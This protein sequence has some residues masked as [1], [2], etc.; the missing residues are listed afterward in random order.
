ME[1]RRGPGRKRPAH[2]IGVE[3]G[4]RESGDPLAHLVSLPPEALATHALLL[5]ATGSGKTTLIH[6][7]IAQDVLLGRSFVILDLRGDLVAAAAGLL[8][9]RVPP[10]RVR[11]LDLRQRANPAGFDPLHGAGEPYFRALGV[12]GAVEAAS[13]SWGVQLAETL[14]SALTLLAA[15]GEPLTRI[16]PLLYDRAFLGSCLTGCEDASLAGFWRRYLEL[17][18]AKQGALAAPVMNKVSL[19]LSTGPLRSIL[20]SERPLDLRRQLDT[21]GSALLVSLA[22]DETH[23][24]GRMMGR[25][26]L[27]SLVREVFARVAIPESRRNPVRLYV[28]EFSHFGE[29]E[30]EG[31]LA[32]GRRFGLSLVVAHQTLAQLA[33]RMRAM[34]LG[35]VGAKVAFRLGRD[36]AAIMSRDLTGDPKA[37]DLTGQRTGEAT[38]WTRRG[39]VREIE[40][41]API[42][43][44]AGGATPAAHRLLRA[45]REAADAA[46]RLPRRPLDPPS[47]EREPGAGRTSRSGVRKDAAS[48]EDWLL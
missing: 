26:F 28:D 41:N 18:D 16:E 5:G 10:E 21:P 25:I 22:A 23:G 37:L 17:S 32:E 45:A 43:P 15:A 2:W 9:G 14:R 20:G 33:P 29:A 34:L 6:H 48:G 40:V 36:D 3:R 1:R 19:L 44:D 7:V 12:H 13:D 42:V 47:M 4:W 27:S 31:I 30:F 38:L 39:G 8:A 35:N 46:P 24:A 11:A